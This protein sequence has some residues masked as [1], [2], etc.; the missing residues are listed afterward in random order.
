MRFS[1]NAKRNAVLVS[2]Y[3]DMKEYPGADEVKRYMKEFRLYPDYNIA[4]YGNLL[5]YYDD[6]RKLYA[7]CGYKSAESWSNQNLWTRYLYDVG[8][9]ARVLVTEE[10]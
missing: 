8:F 4:M 2:I 6:V 3:E 9:V 7:D 1:N 10:Y 5:V